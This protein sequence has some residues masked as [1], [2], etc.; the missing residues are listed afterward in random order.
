MNTLIFLLG[1]CTI[2][3]GSFTSLLIKILSMYFH[4]KGRRKHSQ[5]LLSVLRA[6]IDKCTL[7]V[8]LHFSLKSLLLSPPWVVWR[9]SAL[10]SELRGG[11]LPQ[12][13]GPSPPT[14]RPVPWP[15]R[16]TSDI[17]EVLKV[18]QLS[19]RGH[20][21]AIY[22]SFKGILFWFVFLAAFIW[23]LRKATK[24]HTLELPFS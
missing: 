24:R 17:Y 10:Y 8:Q 12:A 19:G 13:S 3:C 2:H 11:P 4:K 9:W 7:M 14:L 23:G 22:Y 1:K 5:V 20:L 16:T 6:T 15:L 21:R 18:F